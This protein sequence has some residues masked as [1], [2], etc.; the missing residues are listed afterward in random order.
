MRLSEVQAFN[1]SNNV[2]RIG[3]IVQ[4]LHP[5][6]FFKVP[7]ALLVSKS[8]TNKDDA[9]IEDIVTECFVQG[10]IV[11]S[12]GQSIDL[13]GRSAFEFLT[14]PQANELINALMPLLFPKAEK[15]T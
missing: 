11:D 12:S 10:I 13:E 4:L 3:D 14:A 1:N 8:F 9:E 5:D 7:S 2:Q 6:L 15:K